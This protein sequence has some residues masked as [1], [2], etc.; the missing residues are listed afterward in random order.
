MYGLRL[1]YRSWHG[2]ELPFA[3]DGSCLDGVQHSDKLVRLRAALVIGAPRASCSFNLLSDVLPATRFW[4]E[5][6]EPGLNQPATRRD[7]S[8][9]SYSHVRITSESRVRGKPRS[10]A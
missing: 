8:D 10:G 9:R 2:V 1:D 5:P 7:Q 6:A 3:L 4:L